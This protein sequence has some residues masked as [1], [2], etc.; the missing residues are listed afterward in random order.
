MVMGL[1]ADRFPPDLHIFRNYVLPVT[2]EPPAHASMFHAVTAPTEQLVWRAA[3]A[4][5]AAP[6]FFRACGRFLDGGLISNNP[7]LDALTEIHLY[8]VGC[9][10]SHQNVSEYTQLHMYMNSSYIVQAP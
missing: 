10:N 9:S 6:T 4:S 8:K 1:L 5:G 3:R 2:E 7:T